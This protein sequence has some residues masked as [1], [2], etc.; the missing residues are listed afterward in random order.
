MKH[1]KKFLENW[2]TTTT[3]PGDVG[4]VEWD[5]T[6][7]EKVYYGIHKVT[8]KREG[9]STSVKAKFDTGARTSSI[10]FEVAKRLG[11]SEEIIS[12]CKRLDSI[13]IPKSISK[14]E[15]K[16]LETDYTKSITSKFP[17]ITS[18]QIS[19]SSSGFSIRAYIKCTMEYYGNIVETEVNL[20]DRTG[21][22]CEMLVGL[23]DM[24]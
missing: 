14:S 16:K 8:L 23:K 5:Y 19:K 1:L 24:L 12:E 2:V 10:D 6:S 4:D 3:N 13:K 11:I 22:T 17:E 21:L 9:Y 15:Q 18:V 7:K 20:R